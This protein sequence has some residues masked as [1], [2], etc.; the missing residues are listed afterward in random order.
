MAGSSVLF[1][2]QKDSS[3]FSKPIKLDAAVHTERVARSEQKGDTL[4]FNAAAYQVSEN[5]DAERLV[6]KMPGISVNDSGVE[7]NGKSVRHVLLDGQEFFGDDVLPA[8]RNIPA[9]MVKQIEIINRLSDSARETGVDDGQ[10]HIALNVVTKR[11]KGDVL[12]SGRI[13]GNGGV[14]DN[15]NSGTKPGTLYY[16]WK[17]NAIQR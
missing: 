2:Q 5:A 7:A 9:D 12:N 11:K 13:Y 1:A 14:Q 10:G 17:F 15:I 8:L 3:I 4:I 6:S 16:W